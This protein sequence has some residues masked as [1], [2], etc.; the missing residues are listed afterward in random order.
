MLGGCSQTVNPRYYPLLSP[1]SSTSMTR[2]YS[3]VN[4]YLGIEAHHLLPTLGQL[5]LLTGV[6]L[7]KKIGEVVC[8]IFSINE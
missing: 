3:V 8:Y 6:R 1:V 4:D 7:W 5:V 2:F